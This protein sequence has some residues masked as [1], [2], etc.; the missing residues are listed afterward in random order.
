MTILQ[1]EN[2]S[3]TLPNGS[4]LFS[5]VHFSLELDKRN[6][7]IL[8]VRG[9][10]GS[11]KTTL[12]KCLAQ[13]IPYNSGKITLDGR[14]PEQY[15]ITEWRSRV[16]YVP[17]RPPILPGTPAKFLETVNTFSAQKKRQSKC[18]DSIEL[19][20]GWNLAPE[21]WD[22]EWN[23]LSGGEM[24][25]IAIACAISCEPD[26]LLLDEPTSALDPETCELV[27]QSLK[28]YTCIWITHNPEQEHRMATCTLT[29]D[30]EDGAEVSGP[31][32]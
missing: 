25:R 1:V 16:M 15:G 14:T 13:L 6:P 31:C 23:Q 26:I 17:Q 18:V 19:A 24:Q 3:L 5:N 12:L 7:R 28:S 32:K 2:L 11:G 10:S 21:T 22:K 20:A 27:E 30:A 9:P 4:H 29:L 8:A